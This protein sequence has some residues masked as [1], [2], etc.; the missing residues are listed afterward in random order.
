MGAQKNAEIRPSHK[1]SKEVYFC[2][3]PDKYEPLEEDYEETQEEVAEQQET[4]E[5]RKRR[6]KEKKKKKYKKYRKNAR[7]ALGFSWR[8]LVAGLQSMS[9]V[10]VPTSVI[11]VVMPHSTAGRA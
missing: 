3:L 7:K 5:E 6:K 2:M 4:Y 1:T 11:T 9:A 10:F 8:C